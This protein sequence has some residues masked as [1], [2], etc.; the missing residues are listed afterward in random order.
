MFA[1]AIALPATTPPRAPSATAPPTPMPSRAW[2]PAGWR[3]ARR[4]P[5]QLRQR[6]SRIHASPS[7]DKARRTPRTGKRRI[8]G[9]QSRSDFGGWGGASASSSSRPGGPPRRSGAPM[10]SSS[11]S[12]GAGRTRSC[13]DGGRSRSPLGGG[14][15]RSSRGCAEAPAVA[16]TSRAAPVRRACMGLPQGC[17]VEGMPAHKRAACCVVR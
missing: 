11:S 10:S 13:G 17:P 14:G 12:S 4:Q 8:S 3:T 7:P 9:A 5:W 15:R 16:R 6:F 1:D 2:P